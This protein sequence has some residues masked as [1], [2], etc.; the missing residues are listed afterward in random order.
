MRTYAR[1]RKPSP[2]GLIVVSAG[3]SPLKGVVPLSTVIE[4]M[5]FGSADELAVAQTVRTHAASR[6]RRRVLR[7]IARLLSPRP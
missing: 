3:P 4:W 7:R 1:S 5:R 2:F 6:V